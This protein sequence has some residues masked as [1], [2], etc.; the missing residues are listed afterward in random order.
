MFKTLFVII[1]IFIFLIY[2]KS[3]KEHFNE[4]KKLSIK[5]NPDNEILF[6]SNDLINIEKSLNE[7]KFKKSNTLFYSNEVINS[8]SSN[9]GFI[10]KPNKNISNFYIGLSNINSDNKEE[11]IDTKLLDFSI[12]L[13]GNNFLKINEKVEIDEDIEY[14]E[15]D[16][17]YCIDPNLDKCVKSTDTYNYSDKDFLSI[18][19]YNN[20]VHYLIV[21]LNKNG[22]T[23]LLIHK[24]KNIPTFPLTI[25][26]VNKENDNILE[27]YYFTNTDYEYPEDMKWSVE[28]LRKIDYNQLIDPKSKKLR[29]QE[30]I[31]E[32]PEKPKDIDIPTYERGIRILNDDYKLAENILHIKPTIYNI[33]Q[34]LLYRMYSIK[35]LIKSADKNKNNTIVFDKLSNDKNNKNIFTIDENNN[36]LG[37]IKIDLSK[38]V[39]IFSNQTLLVKVVL[40]RGEFTSDKLNYVSNEVKI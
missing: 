12:N 1:F 35:I 17:D 16:L 20:I 15:Q 23:G 25:C 32:E 8:V 26:M 3:N 36:K 21:K 2:L 7:T 5:F 33:N 30:E 4:D 11:I 38:Y 13:L 37:I 39:N 40:R 14:L 9:N 34:K 27:K 6:L 18:V 22:L 19:V 29:E 24:S 28:L 31:I 10:F